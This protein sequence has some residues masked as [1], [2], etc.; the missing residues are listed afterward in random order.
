MRIES[1]EVRTLDGLNGPLEAGGFVA[2]VNVVVGP[3]A[4]GKSSLVRAVRAV[5]YP[6]D[7]DL[8]DVRLSLVTDDGTRLLAHRLGRDIRWLRAGQETVAEYE[9]RI[10]PPALARTP[11][12]ITLAPAS[13]AT[14]VLTPAGATARE[15]LAA[16]ELVDYLAAITGQKLDTS[17]YVGGAAGQ[18]VIIIGSAAVEAG[19]ISKDELDAVAP[20]GYVVKVEQGRCKGCNLTV[21]AGLWQRA[22]AG[23]M[24]E[25]GS[26]GRLI[27]VE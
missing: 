1:L 8:V 26:C 19:V 4:S 2:G 23:E 10:A 11:G 25:C 3:N 20:D 7:G 5:L 14:A 12:T 24:V 15:T 27:Y 16:D 13:R 21:P 6:D 22:R 18:G 17:E 9:L